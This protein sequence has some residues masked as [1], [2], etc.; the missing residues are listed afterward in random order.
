MKVHDKV[1][2][3]RILE[4]T[5]VLINRLGL[6]GWSMDILAADVG[7]A[8]NTLYKIIKSKEELV[9]RVA[10]RNIRSV[11]LRLAEIVE[12]EGDYLDVLKNLINEFP[13]LLKGVSADSMRQMFLEYPAVEKAVR[14]HQDELTDRIIGFIGKG[15]EAGLLRGDVTA[16]FIFDLLR[17]I[18]IFQIGSGAVGDELSKRVELSF[19]CLLFGLKA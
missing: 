13:L 12:E 6:K 10:R 5:A 18:V 19:D 4:R 8:K 1:I 11:Q 9:E 7:I 16:E 2:E 17:A 3:E 15:I 14:L